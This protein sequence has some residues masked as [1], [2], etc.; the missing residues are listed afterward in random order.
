MVFS[1]LPQGPSGRLQC[2]AFTS[3]AELLQV[4][5]PL[6]LTLLCLGHIIGSGIFVLTGVAAHTLAGYAQPARRCK[7]IARY[8]LIERPWASCLLRIAPAKASSKRFLVTG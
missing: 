2:P 4:L 3:A 5:G 7:L 1:C 8:N 6:S